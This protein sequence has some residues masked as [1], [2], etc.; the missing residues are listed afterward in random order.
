MARLWN[1]EVFSLF[2]KHFPCFISGLEYHP[3]K[4]SDGKKSYRF[5]NYCKARDKFSAV[6]NERLCMDVKRQLSAFLLTCR[7]DD[8][9]FNVTVRLLF[10]FEPLRS[11]RLPD[12][13]STASM[14]LWRCA[15]GELPS[16]NDQALFV[17][18]K[19]VKNHTKRLLPLSRLN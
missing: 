6:L 5:F 10:V 16:V 8:G 12:I 11:L 13:S 18:P 17:A 15:D 19:H 2:L 7:D 4:K 14:D 1:F 9:N 3:I